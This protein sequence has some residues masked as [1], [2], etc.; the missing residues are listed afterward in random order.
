MENNDVKLE[1]GVRLVN[2]TGI[3]YRVIA[4]SSNVCAILNDIG[5]NIILPFF[6]EG[7]LL[8]KYNDLYGKDYMYYGVK[9][10]YHQF[11]INE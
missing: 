5:D 9:L 1:R 10:D 8:S 2:G 11:G 7:E 4:V 3:I 6:P